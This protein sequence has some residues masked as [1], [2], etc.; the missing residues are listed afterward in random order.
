MWRVTYR[1]KGS[2]LQKLFFDLG[3]LR[4]FLISGEKNP[5]YRLVEVVQV[6]I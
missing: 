4:R 3:T 5:D 1:L 2:E 6:V